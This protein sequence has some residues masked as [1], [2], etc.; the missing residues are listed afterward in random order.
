MRQRPT[1]QLP[2]EAAIQQLGEPV[3]MAVNFKLPYKLACLLEPATTAPQGGR[4]LV[5][6]GGRGRQNHLFVRFRRF[7]DR[8]HG[9]GWA[10]YHHRPARRHQDVSGQRER[11]GRDDIQVFRAVHSGQRNEY[12]DRNHDHG[13]RYRDGGQRKFLRLSAIAG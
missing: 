13:E 3:G 1:S 10:N 11:G 4:F 7:G 6:H 12:R 5:I 8:R 2:Y 9:A